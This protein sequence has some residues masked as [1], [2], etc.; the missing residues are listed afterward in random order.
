MCTREG[1]AYRLAACFCS[2]KHTERRHFSF[3]QE[4]A[5]LLRVMTRGRK[6][7]DRMLALP[8]DRSCAKALRRHL[9]AAS[10][11]RAELFADT[12]TT[13]PITFHDL[14]ATGITWMAVRGDD[15]LKIMQRAGHD[16]FETTRGYVR[17]AEAVR[18]AF[19]SLFPPLPASL[20][21]ST[22]HD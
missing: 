14:R 13:K 21:G 15:P 3:E 16:R 22:T 2:T 20:F 6:S 5:Q 19:G 8:S 10:V 7:T 9:R 11:K 1:A 4:L 12:D 17:T 18:D